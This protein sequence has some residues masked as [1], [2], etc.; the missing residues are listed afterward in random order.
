MIGVPLDHIAIHVAD[1]E[2]AETVVR[3]L[4]EHE[5]VQELLVPSDK[6]SA[7]LRVTAQR[8]ERFRL[9][10]CEAV[11]AE[12]PIAKW[13]AARGPGTHHVAHRVEHIET[14]LE[15]IEPDV[16]VGGIVDAPGLRQV[17]IEA[18]D[19]GLLHEITQRLDE[20]NFVEDNVAALIEMGGEKH[21]TPAPPQ[22]WS[23]G[24][25]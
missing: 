9:V 11:G 25:R 5:T 22:G 21:S 16:V 6:G 14:A 8:G 3:E 7:R 20:P 12:H 23:G 1:C 15:G 13:I 2:Q 10:L 4:L 19:D 24:R 17:F 18:A